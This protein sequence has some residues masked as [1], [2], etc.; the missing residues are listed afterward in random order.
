ML[1]RTGLDELPQAINIL[2]GEMSFV[3]P[4]ALPKRTHEEAVRMNSRFGERL[5]VTPGLA[6]LAQVYLPRYPSHRLRLKYD[7]L[8]IEKASLWLDV[9]LLLWA[10]WYL[11][12]GRWGKGKLGAGV[13]EDD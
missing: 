6:G 11:L 1:R 10:V 4:R 3:G 9:R 13:R 2:K 7:L 8:Y 5:Q 12:T